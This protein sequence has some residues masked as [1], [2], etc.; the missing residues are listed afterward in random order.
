MRALIHHRV[1]PACIWLALAVAAVTSYTNFGHL[2]GD[3]YSQIFEFAAWKI[4]LVSHGDLRLWEFDSCM[5]PSIQAWAV[6]GI[7]RMLGLLGPDVNPFAVAYIIYFLSGLLSVLSIVVFT[8]AFLPTVAPRLRGDFVIL[9]LF[10]WLV[11]YTNTH[12]NSE[13]ISGHLLLLGVGLFQAGIE[14]PRKR[15][16]FLVGLILGLSFSC[17]FQAGFA[18]LGLMV[19]SFVR[20]WNRRSTGLW[21]LML[22]GMILSVL[23]FTVVADTLFYGRLVF[24]PYNYYHQN[25]ATGTM[26]RFS[27]V[28]PWFFYLFMVAVY[29]PFGP[30]YVVATIQQCLRYPLGLLTSLIAPFVLIHCFIGHKEPRFMLPLLGFMPVL[31]MRAFDDFSQR[32]PA[33]E[34]RR[35]LLTRIFWIIN[36]LACAALLI[37]A[38]TEIGA[39]SY[40]HDH[41][42]KPTLL[43]YRASPHQKLLFY[44]RPDLTVVDSKPGAPTPCPAG[45]NALLAIDAKSTEIPPGLPLAYTLFPPPWNH[46]L[47]GALIRSIGHF[48]LYEIKS[49][50]SQ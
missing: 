7:H 33:L 10:S 27:G 32:H 46:L 26:D 20:T 2:C 44:K 13:N 8:N 22:L 29:L 50:E 37:P 31:V 30:A 1:S 11:L 40:L 23:F 19:W 24:S 41:Y 14:N 25:I 21:F 35:P 4:G 16:L 5:R 3:E 12:F 42:R 38:A 49:I 9:S 43:Y 17:R 18:I 34:T 48:D 47:P 28:S 6:V 39:W 45:F 15:R 36:L